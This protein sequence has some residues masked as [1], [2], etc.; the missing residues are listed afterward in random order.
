MTRS[1]ER[2]PPRRSISPPSGDR[3]DPYAWVGRL[4]D[5][6]PG[7]PGCLSPLLLNLLHLEPGERVHL[8]AG[9]L[10]AYLEGAGVELMAASDNVLRG[11]LTSKHI[12]VPELLRSLR[13]DAGLPIA[14]KPLDE[15]PGIRSY[16]VGETAFALTGWCP[17]TPAVPSPS[18]TSALRSSS[19]PAA[20]PRCT[21]APRR[22]PSGT[23]GRRSWPRSTGPS[24]SR[25]AARC[26]W[27]DPAGTHPLERS[28]RPVADGPAG[29]A[30]PGLL[31]A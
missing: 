31:P 12:D 30:R 27:P 6:H 14:P 1:P 9:Y 2:P 3:R 11:G 15:A 23:V 17:V 26:G 22:W 10:H 28:R 16:D 4:A 24:A 29:A 13:F 18:T 25:A 5:E 19:P 20:P 21:A 7:D 8:P